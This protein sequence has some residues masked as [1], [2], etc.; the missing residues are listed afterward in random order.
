VLDTGEKRIVLSGEKW[1]IPEGPWTGPDILVWEGEVEADRALVRLFDADLPGHKII[2][3]GVTVEFEAGDNIWQS[4][5][6]ALIDWLPI[7]IGTGAG[8]IG[9]GV[10]TY[11]YTKNIPIAVGAGVVGS[12][13]GAAIGY[14][15]SV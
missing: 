9:V 6:A 13:V 11:L 5:E 1:G 12:L 15:I 7:I 14:L 4:R 2:I 3:N 8:G 10:P